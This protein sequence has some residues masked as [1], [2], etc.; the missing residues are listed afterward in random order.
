MIVKTAHKNFPVD[1]LNTHPL[2]RGDWIAYTA[3]IDGV[4]LMATSFMDIK[5][6]QFI[7]TCL[8]AIPGKPRI[9]KHGEVSRPQVAEKYLIHAA[10]IDIHNHV[11]TGSLGCEDVVSTQSLLEAIYW[12]AWIYFHKFVPCLL[13]I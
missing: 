7:S 3:D 2:Q 12:I 4:N 1:L 13:Q 5:K 9:T 6:T 11:R 10:A 8:T